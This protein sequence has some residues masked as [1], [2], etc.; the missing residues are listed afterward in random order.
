MAEDDVAVESV[1]LVARD[2]ELGR[3]R[4]HQLGCDVEPRSSAGWHPGVPRPGLQSLRR[5]AA[6]SSARWTLWSVPMVESRR[7]PRVAWRGTSVATVRVLGWGRSFVCNYWFVGGCGGGES[8]WVS[9]LCGVVDGSCEPDGR[10]L[11]HSP[12]RPKQ[13]PLPRPR[14]NKQ[15]QSWG[16]TVTSSIS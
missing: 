10:E 12:P 13:S 11:S 16:G 4:R 2:P 5:K 1:D 15:S 3:R 8:E 7:P 14:P 9:G 6:T